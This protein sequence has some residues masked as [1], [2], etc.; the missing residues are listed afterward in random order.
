MNTYKNGACHPKCAKTSP[1]LVCACV[2]TCNLS[3]WHG[4]S[5]PKSDALCARGLDEQIV[6]A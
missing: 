1:I 2:Q 4:L 6:L 3:L 5:G